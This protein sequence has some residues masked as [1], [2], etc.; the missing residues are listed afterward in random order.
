MRLGG[1]A[2]SGESIETK[3]KTKRAVPNF[4]Q[5]EA[6]LFVFASGCPTVIFDWNKWLSSNGIVTTIGK[7]GVR[8]TGGGEVSVQQQI[9]PNTYVVP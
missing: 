1:V 6:K 7:L 2:G 3:F 4:G 8:D 5:M 9:D